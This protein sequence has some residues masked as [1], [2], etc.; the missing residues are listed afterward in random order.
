MITL[1]VCTLVIAVITLVGLA[2][3]DGRLVQ[4][5]ALCEK[6][7]ADSKVEAVRV[8]AR[9]TSVDR[10]YDRIVEDHE[11][12]IDTLV[13]RANDHFN[14]I[15]SHQSELRSTNRDVLEMYGNFDMLLDVWKKHTE[16]GLFKPERRTH[17]RNRGT[18]GQIED[19][20]HNT[21]RRNERKR[22]AAKA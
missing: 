18:V 8:N 17:R 16:S 11:H 5:T 7:N 12:R 3:L 14:L 21:L 6:R 19:V 13:K 22:A 2:V 20:A 10:T 1:V 9:I 15:R 4:L